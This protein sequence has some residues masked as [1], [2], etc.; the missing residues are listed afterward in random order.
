MPLNGSGPISLAG[1]TAGQSIALEIGQS[2]TAQISFQT[3]LVR[4]LSGT[5][6]GTQVIM[7]TNFYG[8][9]LSYAMSYLVVGGG[10][11]GSGGANNAYYGSGGGSGVARTGS[12]NVNP[13]TVYTM[14]L[15]GGGGGSLGQAGNGSTSSISS[16]AS[17]TGGFGAAQFTYTGGGNADFGGGT[18]GGLLAG[19]G[20]GSAASGSGS[21]GGI[22]ILWSGNSVRYGGGGAG[23][24]TGSPGAGGG[25][26]PVGG[27]GPGG[28][29]STGGGGG[30]GNATF[31]GGPGGT[32]VCAILVPTSRYSGVFTGS[33]SVS[34]S[35]SNTILVW[36]SS[37]GT[38]TA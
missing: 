17:A 34:T 25:G 1:S 27:G 12:V 4:T 9:S 6:A 38:Y 28:P 32:G 8:K 2:A 14:T 20:A 11:G 26:S 23:S 30:G 33:P 24:N 5:S 22:G 13:G 36:T 18:G 7:P 19:G 35:G 21:N 16:V 37:S 15:G 3:A 10:G 29:G 31:G